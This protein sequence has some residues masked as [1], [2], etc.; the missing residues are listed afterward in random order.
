MNRQ[1]L[2]PDTNTVIIIIIRTTTQ[3]NKNKE[4]IAVF[5][6]IL[7]S[8]VEYCLSFWT[9]VLFTASSSV[10]LGNWSDYLVDGFIYISCRYIYIYVYVTLQLPHHM[11][12]G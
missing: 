12:I 3:P 9:Q 7:N 4:H 10:L 11:L 2:P 8:H 1:L 6:T 5:T